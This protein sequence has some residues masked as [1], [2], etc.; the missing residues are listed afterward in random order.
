MG[1]DKVKKYLFYIVLP[2]W[3]VGIASWFL[4]D[5]VETRALSQ[6]KHAI[7]P[8][9]RPMRLKGVVRYVT[10]DQEKWDDLG[11]A[12]FLGSWLIGM[13]AV[14]AGRLLE[15]LKTPQT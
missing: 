10:P 7:A 9:T 13:G 3:C 5:S 12:G 4:L 14:L 8:Y 11:E 15:R 2:F 6:P 1:R